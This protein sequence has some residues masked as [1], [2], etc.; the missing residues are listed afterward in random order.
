MQLKTDSSGDT[1]LIAGTQTSTLSTG[2]Q[3]SLIVI[4][5]IT[6]TPIPLSKTVAAIIVNGQ[7]L[8][9]D[10]SITIGTSTPPNVVKLTTD[11]AG[12]T[13]LEA[14]GNTATV[15]TDSD[16]H[17]IFVTTKGVAEA[18][19]GALEGGTVTSANTAAKATVP[20]TS[21]A[22]YTADTD[23]TI[24]PAAHSSSGHMLS[25]ATYSMFVLTMVLFWMASVE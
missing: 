22:A 6:L 12:H 25:V 9:M 18:I 21:A 16:G 2:I 20:S 5:G 8:E 24:S 10:N 4:D 15:T 14:S 7:T 1:I 19:L 3:T 23:S 17:T 13:L 11:A